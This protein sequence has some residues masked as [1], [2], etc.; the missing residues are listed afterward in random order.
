MHAIPNFMVFFRD[1]SH[2]GVQLTFDMSL[3]N[4]TLFLVF[5]TT[6]LPEKVCACGSVCLA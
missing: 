2:P 4:V 6:L 1:L 5:I 3:D